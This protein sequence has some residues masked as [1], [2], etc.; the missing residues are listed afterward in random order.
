M[1]VQ[2]N[3]DSA[4]RRP[5]SL[6]FAAAILFALFLSTAGCRS[7]P[8]RLLEEAT[9]AMN[10]DD[11]ETAAR[12]LREITITYPDSPLAPNA[13]YELAGIYHLRI[14]DTAAT[15]ASLMKILTDYPE[16]PIAL[17]AHR[18]LAELYE[19]ELG[20]PDKAIA[21]YQTVLEA[22]LDVETERK[23]LLSLADCYYRLDET[24]E[25]APAYQKALSLPY[26]PASDSA[27][28]R[29]ATLSRI[30]G[31]REEAYRLLGELLAE[32]KDSRKRYEAILAQVEILMDEQRFTEARERLREAQSLFSE[33]PECDELQARLHAIQLDQRSLAEEDGDLEE[34][35][36]RIPWGAGRR[37]RKREP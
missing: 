1:P 21:H 34:L 2:R 15:Y 6:F 18:F 27:Y 16:S 22:E 14:R 19:G 35:Q 11:Y 17:S 30:S 10:A 12:Q 24:D 20:A 8:A 31:A 32:S 26:D 36:K 37:A 7:E 13:H 9:E 33:T 4:P 29:L 23:T 28:L 25:A 3:D 5:F